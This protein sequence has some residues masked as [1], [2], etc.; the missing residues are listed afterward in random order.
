MIASGTCGGQVAS[1]GAGTPER[2]GLPALALLAGVWALTHRYYGISHD[3]VLYAAQAMLRIEPNVFSADLFFRWGSQDRFSAFSPI[4]AIVTRFVG[5]SAASMTI[6]VAA[7]AAWWWAAVSILRT[8]LSGR[9]ALAGAAFA[10]GAPLYYGFDRVFRVAES[11]AT[12]RLPSEAL[13]LLALALWLTG[14]RRVYVVLLLACAALLHPLMA[15]GPIL[16]VAVSEIARHGSAARAR[17]FAATVVVT[18]GAFAFAALAPSALPVMDAQWYS[19]VALRAPI[20]TP[21]EWSAAQWAS[22]LFPPAVL[23]AVRR[24]ERD[25]RFVPLWFA[26]ALA[27]S[28]AIALTL[29]AAQT[30]W[31][32]LL[33]VQPWRIGWLVTVVAAFG[34]ARVATI[35]LANGR[36]ALAAPIVAVLASFALSRELVAEAGAFVA[37]ASALLL[38]VSVPRRAPSTRALAPAAGVFAA[39]VIG[40]AVAWSAVIAAVRMQSALAPKGS[41]VAM[42]ATLAEES[43]WWI[44]PVSIGGLMLVTARRRA[45]AAARLAP[46]IA[47]AVAGTWLFDAR[48]PVTREIEDRMTAGLPEW[49]QVVQRSAAVYWHGP[50]T[51]PWFVLQRQSYLSVNQAAGVVFSRAVAMEVMRRIEFTRHA[52]L[53]L[54]DMAL[55]RHAEKDRPSP[56]PNIEGL[57]RLCAD[58]ALGHAVLRDALDGRSIATLHEAATG[59]TYHLFDCASVRDAR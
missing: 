31:V 54:Q 25:D 11:F 18:A 23:L 19:V 17:L 51:Y 1:P 33:Q 28:G 12:A 45:H 34:V 40:A 6:V 2:W 50:I 42:L 8:L 53:S 16:V 55:H 43:V 37:L 38:W 29:L 47:L 57:R 3:G 49:Q 22:S 4:F 52:G 32:L 46:C 39:L 56:V 35:E 7:Q 59:V 44:A 5:L 14:G 15:A 36:R 27:G 13:G 20:V 30:R 10:L 48:Y 9:F 26:A 24:H 58:P 21:A 41:A